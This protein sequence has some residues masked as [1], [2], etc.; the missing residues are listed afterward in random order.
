MRRSKHRAFTL[1][2][3]LIVIAIIALLVA[4]LLPAL[5]KARVAAI[6]A[7]C[8]SNLRQNGLLMMMYAN[9]YN[10]WFPPD[11]GPRNVSALA[12]IPTL[13]LSATQPYTPSGNAFVRTNFGILCRPG[14]TW[15]VVD[16]MEYI[17]SPKSFYCPAY[18]RSDVYITNQWK[19]TN[20]PAFDYL[21]LANPTAL[22]ATTNTWR[23]MK[24]SLT[25]LRNPN[26][27]MA[28]GVNRLEKFGGRSKFPSAYVI[29]S[30]LIQFGINSGVNTNFPHLKLKNTAFVSGMYGG[31]L[32]TGSA[33]ALFADG[34]VD[35]L[36]ASEWKQANGTGGDLWTPASSATGQ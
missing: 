12:S 1:V 25:N 17:K 5:S 20:G 2:E 13:E 32:F 30:D 23:A 34:H 35:T 7:A 21:Y 29:V 11:Y 6:R 14:H 22:D 36:D 31:T 33:N 28:Y 18:G 24:S 27:G 3:L 8:G 9:D 4:I 15:S 10:G 16:G 19:N 26:T